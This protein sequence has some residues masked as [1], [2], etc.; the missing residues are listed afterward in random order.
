M[1]QFRVCD[2]ARA[3][4]WH[5]QLLWSARAGD[6]LLHW[7]PQCPSPALPWAQAARCGHS[8]TLSRSRA[9]AG[10]WALCFPV[11]ALGPR[12]QMCMGRLDLQFSASLG[13]R[14][15]A[16]FPTWTAF[17]PGVCFVAFVVHLSLR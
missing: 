10:S 12:E 15:A 7:F 1:G 5:F 14:A 11:A 6:V 8:L 9:A 16:A 3:H 13:W 4:E 17:L 2:T